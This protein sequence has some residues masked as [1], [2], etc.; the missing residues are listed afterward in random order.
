[1]QGKVGKPSMDWFA[2][3][4][5][6]KDHSRV[7]EMCLKW[8]N[9]GKWP[10]LERINLRLFKINSVNWGLEDDQF[11]DIILGEFQALICF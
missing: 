5:I 4:I 6:D 2:Y 1:M 3:L 7:R 9:K 11:I 10:K 8:I